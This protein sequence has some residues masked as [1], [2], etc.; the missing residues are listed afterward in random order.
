MCASTYRPNS[1]ETKLT[2]NDYYGTTH[3][4]KDKIITTYL[5]EYGFVKE[6]NGRVRGKSPGKFVIFDLEGNY[7]QTWEAGYEI[8]NFVYDEENNRLIIGVEDADVQFA[9]LDLK[10]LL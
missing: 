7:L 10:G 1:G 2:K 3:F 4:C 9:Y 5:A 8:T 6:A